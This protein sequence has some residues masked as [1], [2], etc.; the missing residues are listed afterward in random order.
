MFNWETLDPNAVYPDWRFNVK[1]GD[2]KYLLTPQTDSAGGSGAWWYLLMLRGNAY[3]D[4]VNCRNLEHAMCVASEW[5][6]R[7]SPRP[8][9]RI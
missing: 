2:R 8:G 6:D 5:E 4:S 1:S 7:E 9:R 3:A